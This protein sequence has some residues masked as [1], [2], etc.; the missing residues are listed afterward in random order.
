LR[1]NPRN[2]ELVR[3]SDGG[4][5]L[6]ITDINTFSDKILPEYF[7]HS[8]YSS[9]I[10]QLNMYGFRKENKEKKT[11]Q[12][13]YKHEFFR[14][15]CKELLK[16]IT[17]KKRGEDEAEDRLQLQ[18]ASKHGRH[19]P[20]SVDSFDE[21]VYVKPEILRDHEDLT[22]RVHNLMKG[23]EDL[24]REKEGIRKTLDKVGKDVEELKGEYTNQL[25][26]LWQFLSK[27]DAPFVKSKPA[28]QGLNMLLPVMQ[29]RRG[30]FE[31]GRLGSFSFP[32]HFLNREAME[33]TKLRYRHMN[34]SLR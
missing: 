6:I 28:T 12:E 4:E 14:R 17:R 32:K 26:L 15:G 7:N 21:S 9:F 29:N 20:P 24:E 8:N 33:P 23:Y 27:P 10:R 11:K 2:R 1:Q 31:G 30:V 3:W 13:E 19:R 34:G 16:N 22:K 18:V 5:T 25:D